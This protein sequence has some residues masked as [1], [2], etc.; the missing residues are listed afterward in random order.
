M[1]SIRWISILFVVMCFFPVPLIAQSAQEPVGLGIAVGGAF[2]QGSTDKIPST[3][4]K[5]SLNWGFYVNIPLIYTFHLTPSAE[6]Y[7]FGDQYATDIAIAFKFI[8]PISSVSLYAGFVPGLTA[9][10]DVIAPHFG[11]LGGASFNLVSNLDLFVQAKYKFLFEADR[12]IR[13][14]HLNGGVL[15]KF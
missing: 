6:L 1:K 4:W 13:V 9:V 2:P 8:V 15:F 14:L 12:N 11:I 7:Q 3:D 5:L 10:S